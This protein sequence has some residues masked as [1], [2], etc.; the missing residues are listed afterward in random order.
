MNREEIKMNREEVRKNIKSNARNLCEYVVKTTIEY[1]EELLNLEEDLLAAKRKNI[2][3]ENSNSNLKEQNDILMEQLVESDTRIH[4]LIERLGSKFCYN[5]DHFLDCD[6]YL[7]VYCQQHYCSCCIR[8]CPE[9]TIDNYCNFLICS[10]CKIKYEK[11][12]TH[13]NI[14]DPELLAYYF[15]NR[16]K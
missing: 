11:C 13:K 12:P 3:L 7:C 9:V 10:N 2:K 15:E 14:Q 1:K 8:V 6:K 16:F 5:C 4:N